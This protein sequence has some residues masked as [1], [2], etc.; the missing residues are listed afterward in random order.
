VLW[1]WCF[2]SS[3]DSLLTDVPQ[4]LEHI[5]VEQQIE[6]AQEIKG[7]VDRLINDQNGNHVVQKIIT[8]IPPQH[9][10]FVMDT[11]RGQVASLSMSQLGCRV[12]QRLLDNGFPEDVAVIHHEL[13]RVAHALMEDQYGNYVAQHIIRLGP[14]ELRSH[15]VSLVVTKL[16]LVSC[17]KFASNVVESCIQYG[18]KQELRTI[19]DVILHRPLSP[20]GADVL[21]AMMKD[22][23]GNYVIREWGV[24]R[25]RG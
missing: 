4:A 14:S 11:V 20:G 12:I 16:L 24:W 7:D 23:F 15:F 17:Q 5:L 19:L 6:L 22:Q 21:L 2:V 3:F 25:S 18:S 1:V 10:P 8:T 9:I 13:K